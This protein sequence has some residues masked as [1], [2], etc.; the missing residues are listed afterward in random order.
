MLICADSL[1]GSPEREVVL[2]SVSSRS[3]MTS[4]FVQHRSIPVVKH[5]SVSTGF[6]DL[7]L[8][9]SLAMYSDQC[10]VAEREIVHMFWDMSC[11]HR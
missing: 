11:S 2:T 3:H 6:L 9:M 5:V 1:A 8:S 10:E 4:M 7:V